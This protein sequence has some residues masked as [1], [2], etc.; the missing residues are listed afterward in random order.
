MNTVTNSGKQGAVAVKRILGWIVFLSIWG[1]W[2]FSAKIW[3]GNSAIYDAVAADDGQTIRQLIDKGADPNSQSQ[4]I[5]LTNNR[6]AVLK[7]NY[8]PL[9]YALRHVK[10]SA[11]LALVEGGANPNALDDDG[12][13]ALDMARSLHLDKVVTALTQRGAISHRHPRFSD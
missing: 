1:V 9:I 7:Y 12:E 13:S 10:A 6:S 5:A 11:A 2:L 3:P 8:P 4:P